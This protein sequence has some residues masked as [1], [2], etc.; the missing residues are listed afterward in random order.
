MAEKSYIETITEG[1]VKFLTKFIEDS[2]YFINRFMVGYNKD[3]LRRLYRSFGTPQ[4]EVEKM[5]LE[6]KSYYPIDREFVW[7]LYLFYEA[8]ENQIP[9]DKPMVVYR[10]CDTLEDHA[11]DGVTATSLNK[12]IAENFNYG[13]LLKINIPAG[14]KVITCSE[15]VDDLEEQIILP[16]CDYSIVGEH[17]E[18]I[19]GRVTRVVEL[20]ITPR[21]ILKDFSIAMQ[22]PTN[23]YR[24]EN[25]LGDRYIE[26]FNYLVMIMVRRAL[27]VYPDELLKKAIDNRDNEFF[28]EENKGKESFADISIIEFLISTQDKPK[29]VVK[30]MLRQKFY[31]VSP[32]EL[33]LIYGLVR[34]FNDSI[35]DDFEKQFKY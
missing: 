3:K 30:H 11:M 23:D 25:G 29:M 9:T 33:D 31:Y 26:A 10:G 18:V 27:N 15:F 35:K 1:T 4:D 2:A 8:M 24:N 16:P 20:N 21:D 7:N 28:A 6:Q 13:T 14:S 22:R 34:R 17:K 19:D 5:V 32:E 12:K